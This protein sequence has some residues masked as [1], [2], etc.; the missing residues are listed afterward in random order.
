MPAPNAA[1]E[2]ATPHRTHARG[3]GRCSVAIELSEKTESGA[4]ETPGQRKKK[5]VPLEGFEPPTRSLGRSGSSTE[6]Q[7]QGTPSLD[8]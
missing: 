7:R 5:V 4:P 3:G 6:L 2:A 1:E 8:G